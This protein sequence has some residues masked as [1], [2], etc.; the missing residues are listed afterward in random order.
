MFP[1]PSCVTAGTPSSG[2]PSSGG[3]KR[4]SGT[5]RCV[6]N[7]T[8]GR[9]GIRQPTRRALA[10]A[11][12]AWCCFLAVALLA[13][14]S[15]AQSSTVGHVVVVARWFGAPD[16]LATQARMEFVCN[17]LILMPLSALGSLLWPRTSWRD[18]TA[19]AFVVAGLVE[20]TQGLLLSAR[21][22]SFVDVVA[23]TLGG[24]GGAVAVMLL[25]W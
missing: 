7:E 10:I 14:S 2:S 16:W 11:L 18:W 22:A 1:R 21:T 20:L 15:G 13:P 17:A 12:V 4:G 8:V 24:L 23:N 9:V 25:R 19:Y 3:S 5:S 6:R